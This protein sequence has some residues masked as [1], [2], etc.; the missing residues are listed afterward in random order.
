MTDSQK[1]ALPPIIQSEEIAIIDRCISD[2]DVVFDIGA[3]HGEWSQNV[4]KLK[5]CSLHLF[6]A[7]PEAFSVLQEQSVAGEMLNH[8][9]VAVE[10]GH[11]TFHV[12]RD[13]P[14]LSSTY[15]RHSV[16]AALM[17]AGFNAYE[18]PC[19]SLD[20]YWPSEKGL[21]N[22][23]KIDVEGAEYDV[24][25][26]AN[27]LLRRGGVDYIQ[28]EY[29]GTFADS[30]T[31]LK[32]L[33]YHLRR[34]RYHLFRVIG[35]SFE[36][37]TEFDDSLEDFEYSNFLAV[38]ERHL[39]RFTGQKPN[40]RVY[41]EELEELNI[42]IRGVV[43]I[44]AHEGREVIDYRDRGVR[45]II[46]IEAN[47]KYAAKLRERYQDASDVT[48]IEGAVSDQA[49]VATFNIASSDQ[50]SSLLPLKK[51]ADLYPGIVYTEVIEVEAFTL[52]ERLQASVTNGSETFPVNMIVMD[53]QGAELMA[54]RGGVKSLAHIDAIQLEVNYDELYEGCPSIWEIDDFL[55]KHGF[56][57]YKTDTPFSR[58]W[59][60]ALYVRR[61]VVVNSTVGSLGRFGN[62][63]FQYGFLR[64]HAR[65]M[66]F[67]FENTRWVGDQ[68]FNVTLGTTAAGDG[69]RAV[70]QKTYTTEGCEILNSADRLGNA[71]INGFFQY[72]TNFYRRHREML[73][74]DFSFR[75]LYAKRAE[76]I[77]AN[78]WNR[79]GLIVGA[80][81]RRGDYGNRFFYIAPTAWYID[82]LRDLQRDHPKLTVYIASDELSKISQD[83]AEFDI[84]TAEDLDPDGRI[85]P[86]FFDDFAALTMCDKVA[87]SNSS[88]SFAATML[89][90]RADEFMRP[91]LAVKKLTP[92]DPWSSQPLLRTELAEDHGPEFMK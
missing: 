18:V 45:Q 32:I 8:M 20:D 41:F 50:S 63:F 72:N 29:G 81:L 68:M 64:C 37:I 43:H 49:G 46:M 2:G 84:L 69:L 56:I 27:D 33:Y 65:D 78:F 4:H 87:I 80:H 48:V 73:R 11:L 54:L 15:R 86:T 25:R 92:Y 66:G 83:F 38:N 67:H 44:G 47:P 34:L 17:P 77:A 21:I 55:E 79:G 74:A 70:S 7:S 91:D 60:D 5:N 59:G 22:F 88:F 90:Q 75:G 30:G 36:E 19:T 42:P 6:E 71:N 62:Q 57:R 16:E 76:H 28:F 24:L 1:P 39:S 3:F 40:I 35:D 58:D 9:A 61:P 31:T 14:R 26:G 13:K 12:Y 23:L 82:W 89:N 52:D 85:E 53:I 51:H 10:T